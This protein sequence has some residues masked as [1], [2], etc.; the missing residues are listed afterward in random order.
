[1]IKSCWLADRA[2]RKQIRRAAAASSK[3]HD[4]D[5]GGWRGASNVAAYFS[6]NLSCKMHIKLEYAINGNQSLLA[7]STYTDTYL[8]T[9]V[10]LS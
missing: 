5:E 1:M 3:R 9:P 7:L 6:G 4:C 2:A 10:E 8:V